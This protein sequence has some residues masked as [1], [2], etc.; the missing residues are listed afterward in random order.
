MSGSD[1][2]SAERVQGQGQ[3]VGEVTVFEPMTI[4]DISEGGAQIETAFALHNDSLHDF[5][6]TLDERSVVVKGRVA[7]CKI[8]E[9]TDG[10]VMY[11]SGIEFVEPAPHVL[12]A[13][14]EFVEAHR[15]PPPRIIDAELA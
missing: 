10:G 4:V 11:S 12:E 1:K 15:N 2:R 5:R 7:Y 13:I 3:L 14:G 6:L 9:L 8:A